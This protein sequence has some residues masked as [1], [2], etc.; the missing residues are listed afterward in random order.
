MRVRYYLHPDTGRPHV[1]NRGVAEA[2]AEH[3]LRHPGED[4]PGARGSR[5]AIGRT[6]MGVPNELVPEVREL[7]AKRGR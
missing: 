1:Y 4:R 2:E 7:I 6:F 5:V 3:V